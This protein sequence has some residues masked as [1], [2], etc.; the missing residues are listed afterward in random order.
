MGS[1]EGLNVFS[2]SPQTGVVMELGADVPAAVPQQ[3]TR[4]SPRDKEKRLGYL[5]VTPILILLASLIV[6]P[7]SMP[8]GS[9]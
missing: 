2:P 1:D 6:W 9:A 8:S 3:K 5:L 7:F 4:R